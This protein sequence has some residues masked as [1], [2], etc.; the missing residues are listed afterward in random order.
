MPFTT[1]TYYFVGIDELVEQAA[2][3]LA[4]RH[5]DRARALVEGLP[6]RRA[7]AARST[8][9]VVEVLVGPDPTPQSL[10]S[11]Y[12]RYLRA[13]R[14]PAL[15]QVVTDWNAELHAL[16]AEVLERTG[17]RASRTQVQLL[18]AALD[19]LLITALAEGHE[20]PVGYAVRVAAPLVSGVQPFG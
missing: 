18:V 7:S 8:G 15:R 10:Q 12:E 2:A 4:R 17:R 14:T 20:D 6:H 3:D 13:G 5:L 19:G 16:A 1:I 11:L 9:L